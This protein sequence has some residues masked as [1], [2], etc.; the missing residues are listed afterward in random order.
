MTFARFQGAPVA[1]PAAVETGG[2]PWSHA[3]TLE[4]RIR[5]RIEHRLGGRIRDLS[6]QIVGKSVILGGE[7]ATY[8]S[9]QLAQHA[10]LGVIE[11]EHLENEIRVG[12]GG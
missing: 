1:H 11:D 7:C 6:V 8:Y 9:K 12:V 10:A 5:G 3:A 4:S 2:A